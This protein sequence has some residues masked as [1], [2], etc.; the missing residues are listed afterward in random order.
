M[1]LKIAARGRIA[2]F[3]VMDVMRAANEREAAGEAVLTTATNTASR[4]TPSGW[5]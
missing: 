4:W 3:I 2:P 1:A 5:S